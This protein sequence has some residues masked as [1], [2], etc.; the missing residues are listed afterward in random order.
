MIFSLSLVFIAVFLTGISQVLLKIGAVHQGTQKKSVL[1]AYLNLPV[2]AA[3]GLLIF[4]TIITVIAL[5]EVPLKMVYA[6]TSLNFIVV[7]ILSQWI[8]KEHVGKQM[9]LALALIIC[10]VLVFNYPL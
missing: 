3:Y 1:A 4:V 5:M 10:G 8:L 2:M 9:I 7:T 6:I